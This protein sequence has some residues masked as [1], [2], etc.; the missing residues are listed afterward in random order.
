MSSRERT[1]HGTVAGQPFFAGP[2]KRASQLGH[3]SLDVKILFK[4]FA[5]L[6]PELLFFWRLVFDRV[7]VTWFH[8]FSLLV[9]FYVMYLSLGVF[10]VL[11]SWLFWSLVV[12][13]LPKGLR[14]P[15]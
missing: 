12:F 10:R 3:L 4:G 13:I 8:G 2:S 1:P 14:H 6:S 7:D 11:D 15:V 9:L 5:L